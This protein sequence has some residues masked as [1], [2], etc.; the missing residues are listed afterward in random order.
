MCVCVRNNVLSAANRAYK[1][2]A[3]MLIVDVTS[4]RRQ[5]KVR[6]WRKTALESCKSGTSCGANS[7]ANK[8]A[9]LNATVIPPP[10]NGCLMLSASPIEIKPAIRLMRGGSHEFGM[11]RNLPAL[12]A[13]ANDGRTQ[14][15]RLGSTMC[16]RWLATPP[17]AT[18]AVGHFSGMSMRMRVSCLPIW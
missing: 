1:A 15:G 6:I 3:R 14:A 2:C 7:S 16:S 4:F 13:R 9:S 10:V 17:A 11:L 12:R 18:L 5:W 8:T